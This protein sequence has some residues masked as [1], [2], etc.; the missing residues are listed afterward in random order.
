MISNV[1]G[2]C[3]NKKY[4]GFLYIVTY[5]HQYIVTLFLSLILSL[6]HIHTIDL[7]KPLARGR[8]LRNIRFLNRGQGGPQAE[9]LWEEGGGR[10]GFARTLRSASQ[11]V[12][13]PR[14]SLPLLHRMPG[15][16]PKGIKPGQLGA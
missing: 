15:L 9:D 2:S 16:W 6:H 13:G 12:P 11:Y 10:L 8:L 4:R 3:K 7:M 14:E 5:I 1:Q